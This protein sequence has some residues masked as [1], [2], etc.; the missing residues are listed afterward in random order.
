MYGYTSILIFFYSYVSGCY[1]CRKSLVKM[2]TD[3][4]LVSDLRPNITNKW[5]VHVIVSH[6]WR[7]YN[8]INNRVISFD[9]ILSDQNAIF[10]LSI[11]IYCYQYNFLF[12]LTLSYL[13]KSCIYA[14]I[15]HSLID[16]F[17][18]KFIEGSVYR[19]HKFEVIE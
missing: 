1:K 7:T 10:F 14:T 2:I 5:K 9:L 18:N 16:S 3:Y 12:C 15:P 13:Q 4:R 19:I 6:M 8:P 11:N 17:I